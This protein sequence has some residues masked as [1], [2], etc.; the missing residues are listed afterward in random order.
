MGGP[1]NR[2]WPGWNEF[3]HSKIF[4]ERNYPEE[5]T[6]GNKIGDK[7]S[8]TGLKL[9]CQM[10]ILNPEKRIT[11]SKALQDPWFKEEPLPAKFEDMPK[12]KPLNEISREERKKLKLNDQ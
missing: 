8:P 10:L 4:K 6:L 2:S 12:F 1:T 3:K 5:C 9:L 11:A 7:I